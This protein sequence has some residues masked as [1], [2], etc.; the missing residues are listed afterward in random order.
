MSEID[1]LVEELRTTWA[2]SRDAPD[3]H[4]AAVEAEIAA[5]KVHRASIEQ[6]K[7]VLMQLLSVD[8]DTAFAILRRYSQ[9]HNVKLRVLAERLAEAATDHSTPT[10][11]EGAEGEVDDLL[12]R[13]A[14]R[15][16]SDPGSATRAMN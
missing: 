8:A 5:F 16:G 9:D 15:D 11:D 2:E 12:K 4:T 13:L 3:M 1:V 10:R 7:G 6:A 14:H